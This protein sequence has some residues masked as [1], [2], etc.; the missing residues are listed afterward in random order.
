M[1]AAKVKKGAT[2]R[3]R[4]LLDPDSA[5]P[6]VI[7]RRRKADEG[8]ICWCPNQ[9]LARQIA[10]AL[11]LQEKVRKERRE[12]NAWRKYERNLEAVCGPLEGF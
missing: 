4:Y 8:T 12:E 5:T 6:R 1:K 3:T 7:D 9:G 11:N 2:P 10:A